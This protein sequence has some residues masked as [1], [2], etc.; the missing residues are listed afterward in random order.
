MST[1][2]LK[3]IMMLGITKPLTHSS[4]V[5]FGDAQGALSS[6]QDIC[7]SSG[8]ISISVDGR[9]VS[10][11]PGPKGLPFIGNYFDV[12]PDHLG[13]HQRLFEHY[14]PVIKT[15]SVGRVTYLTNDPTVAAIVFAESDF[16]TKEI[17]QNHPL[18]PIKNKAAGVFL[19][20]THTEEWKIAH[21]FLPPALGP[22]AVRHYAPTMQKTVEDAFN[23]FDELDGKGMSWN[24]YQY[25][26]KLGA[27]AVGKLVLGMDFNHFSSPNTYPHEMVRCIAEALEL[28]KKI[29]TKGDW[30][31]MLP[32]GDAKKLQKIQDRMYELVGESIAKAESHGTEDLPLQD[33]ALQASNMVDYAV[34]ATDSKGEKLPK[35]SLVEALVVATGAGFTTT[36]SLLSWLIYGLVT[37]PGMQE[38]LLQELIDN[39]IDENTQFTADVTEK[40]P[41]LDKYIKETQRRHNPSFQPGRTARADLILP[42]GYKIPEDAVVIPAIHHIHNNPN[43]WDNPNS[44]DPNRWDTEQVKNRHKAA[45]VPFGTGQRMCV[46]FN[47]ALQEVKIFL[48]KL[49]YR[50]KFMPEEVGTTEYD[51]MF[52]LIRPVNLYVRAERRVKWPAPSGPSS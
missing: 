15:E 5:T 35:T 19:G 50:Y 52:Q 11:P 48:P 31:A 47:F 28:N 42:G 8:P 32:F 12:F 49:V 18:Y 6:F 20:D 23:V 10:D 7:S 39:G 16:F 43:L 22:K 25:M 27:Q 33:A 44:F 1:A 9:A 36:S 4:G 51:P 30:Y 46:G 38:R 14:G 21:K 13:N 41:F 29:S 34:R 24:V 2:L 37:Y 40:L 3:N 45:Y 17:N 26:L